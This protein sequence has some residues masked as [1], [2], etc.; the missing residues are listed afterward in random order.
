MKA[1]S[2]EE[3]MLAY[4]KGNVAAF[5]ELFARHGQ[6]VYNLFLRS[7][8]NA[9]IA[10]DLTQETFLRV[11]TARTR[12]EPVRTFS[13]WL[14]TIAMNL[15]R[16]QIRKRKRQENTEDLSSVDVESFYAGPDEGNAELLAAVQKALQTLPVEQR[17]V[18]MLAKYQ[19]RSYAEIANILGIAE[20]AAKQR[21]YR[22]LQTLRA[23][24]APE[25]THSRGER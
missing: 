17:E 2:D 19:A 11:V 10:S 4:A 1:A 3:L 6:K 20:T 9:T 15:L 13:S 8:G 23:L 5:D 18:I 25:R 22:A 16:D 12:Y 14:Y 7:L 24:L 21:A